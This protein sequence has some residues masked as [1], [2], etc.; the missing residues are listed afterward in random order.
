MAE[1]ERRGQRRQ[2]QQQQQNSNRRNISRPNP[3]LPPSFLS[4]DLFPPH[5]RPRACASPPHLARPVLA[6]HDDDLRVGECAGV[7]R[8]VEVSERLGHRRVLVKRKL[9]V[10]V[11]RDRLNHLE[12]ER[13]VAEAQVLRRD[14]AR[15]EHVDALAHAKGQRHDA[16]RAWLAVQAADKV[17]QVVE[18]RQVVLDDDNVRV[19]GKQFADDL[20]GERRGGSV[21]VRNIG[22]VG[23]VDEHRR[24]RRQ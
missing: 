7:D 5:P 23:Q 24:A 14:K 11:L 15:E 2:Q 19:D 16:V 6:Q 8:H 1:E 18:H 9:L 10:G 4:T 22:E 17:R 13:L 20:L 12:R 21:W 3:L